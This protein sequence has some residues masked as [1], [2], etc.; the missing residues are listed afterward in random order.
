M[1]AGDLALILVNLLHDLAID[2]VSI[3][4]VVAVKGGWRCSCNIAIGSSIDAMTGDG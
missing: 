2:K 4:A 3:V 1:T